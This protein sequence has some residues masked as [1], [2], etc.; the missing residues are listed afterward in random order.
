MSEEK[1]THFLN[2]DLDVR[3][4]SGLKKLIDAFAPRVFELGLESDDHKSFEINHT[5]EEYFDA[6]GT[7]KRPSI[8]ETILAFYN[9]VLALPPSAMTIWENAES[10]SFDIGI[11]G[12]NHPRQPRFLVSKENIARLSEMEAEL[13]ITVYAPQEPPKKKKAAKIGKPKSKNRK[14]K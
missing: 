1:A 13:V 3:A 9:A 11:Q 12:G 14:R 2:V 8:D 4:K 6:N 5:R 10:R 7:P